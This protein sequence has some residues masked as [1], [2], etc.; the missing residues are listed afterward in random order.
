VR[1]APTNTVPRDEIVDVEISVPPVTNQN[2]TVQLDLA[3]VAM[4][5]QV[6]GA[7]GS[8]QM[9]D[10][11]Q[12]QSSGS[13]Q[14]DITQITLSASNSWQEHFKAVFNREGTVNLKIAFAIGTSG[15]DTIVSQNIAVTKQ[16]REYGY[17]N[18]GYNFN[19]YDEA[20]QTAYDYWGG[21]YSYPIDDVDRLKAMGM[22]ESSLG[23]TLAYPGGADDIMSYGWT[24]DPDIHVLHNDPTYVDENGVTQAVPPEREYVPSLGASRQ[25]YYPAAATTPPATAIYWATCEL[26]HKAQVFDGSGNFRFWRSWDSATTKYN[27]GGVNDYLTRVHRVML[28]GETPDGR[29]YLWPIETDF[30]A[31][32]P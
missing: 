8:V 15:T 3:P 27:G 20:F 10:F 19:Q 6:L 11:C 21:F 30:S 23:Q 12:L 16:I 26:Y 7:R 18:S 24:L 2:L 13:T 4:K 14:T 1:T 31:R 29:S 9:Y 32:S 28:E 5:T 17:D 25:I 22:D